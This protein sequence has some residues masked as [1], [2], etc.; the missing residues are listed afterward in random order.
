M[1][2][3]Q[4]VDQVASPSGTSAQ[5]KAQEVAESGTG[6]SPV[7]K[8]SHFS[9]SEVSETSVFPQSAEAN[10]AASNVSSRSNAQTSSDSKLSA[11]SEEANADSNGSAPGAVVPNSD[12]VSLPRISDGQ[13]DA[14]EETQDSRDELPPG[15]CD[16]PTTSP[17]DEPSALQPQTKDI[18]AK[19]EGTEQPFATAESGEPSTETASETGT[20]AEQSSA[21]QPA[22][23]VNVAP[24]VD[25]QKT[26]HCETEQLADS[27][28]NKELETPTCRPPA[29]GENPS[30]VAGSPKKLPDVS[31]EA[32]AISAIA[33]LQKLRQQQFSSKNVDREKACESQS[34]TGASAGKA[35]TNAPVPD[36]K[37]GQQPENNEGTPTP[38]TAPPVQG[39]LISS[40]ALPKPRKAVEDEPATTPTCSNNIPRQRDSEHAASDD[41][42][43]VGKRHEYTKGF[44]PGSVL[45][46]ADSDSRTVL[47]TA[48]SLAG[49]TRGQN[50]APAMSSRNHPEHSEVSPSH[51]LNHNGVAG[52]AS[53]AGGGGT[54]TSMP[55]PASTGPATGSSG[56]GSTNPPQTPRT[57]GNGDEP[58]PQDGEPGDAQTG[59]SESGRL[60]TPES[61]STQSATPQAKQTG[62]DEE[63]AKTAAKDSKASPQDSD[64][65]AA[66]PLGSVRAT[67]SSEQHPPKNV[68]LSDAERA[69]QKRI[70]AAKEAERDRLARL[71]ASRREGKPVPGNRRNDSARSANRTLGSF[72]TEK[73]EVPTTEEIRKGAASDARDPLKTATVGEASGTD[74]ANRTVDEAALEEQ[75]KAKASGTSDA[76]E[77]ARECTQGEPCSEESKKPKES[78]TE[79]LDD[80]AGSKSDASSEDDAS[81]TQ[82]DQSTGEESVEDGQSSVATPADDLPSLDETAGP[83]AEETATSGTAQ[84]TDSE[85]AEPCAP[86]SASTTSRAVA[87]DVQLSKDDDSTDDTEILTDSGQTTTDDSTENPTAAGAPKVDSQNKADDDEDTSEDNDPDRNSPDVSTPANVADEA[88]I[89]NDQDSGSESEQDQITSLVS[90]DDPDLDDSTEN[91]EEETTETVSRRREAR[92]AEALA[93]YGD[94]YIAYSFNKG[95]NPP[96]QN[97]QGWGSRGSESFR[98]Y[99][100]SPVRMP[101][102]RRSRFR[103]G[104]RPSEV[105]RAYAGL[106]TASIN[107][108]ATSYRGALSGRQPWAWRERLVAQ[109]QPTAKRQRRGARRRHGIVIT[110]LVLLCLGTTG[111]AAAS[112]SGVWTPSFLQQEVKLAD[113]CDIKPSVLPAE[114]VSVVILNASRK[115]GLAGTVA[116]E[117]KQRDF[118]IR[119][120]GDD[121]K[122]EPDAPVTIRFGSKGAPQARTVQA[123]FPGAK[124]IRDDRPSTEV[125]VSL[126][127]KFSSL[128]TDEEATAVIDRQLALDKVS[129]DACLNG[130]KN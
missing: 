14:L 60:N 63:A 54:Q 26:V 118:N 4:D 53:N 71:R 72:S 123:H 106:P 130:V 5:S 45:A 94:H 96:P 127:N 19:T 55:T 115:A 95:G 125:T 113:D 70:T 30:V 10:P 122:F 46:G 29:V 64:N 40:A 62:A 86:K 88:V 33:R 37:I 68:M 1:P 119:S 110:L 82:I 93:K 84:E 73:Q 128:A 103:L 15:E 47:A 79:E 99:V 13:V 87:T 38:S 105:D 17:T 124:L 35:D 69:R 59:N 101:I 116:A 90:D 3:K 75:T 108:P 109:P 2:G 111:A 22:S 78:S 74:S 129:K 42:A 98:Y 48:S 89:E 126:Q 112:L 23:K 11:A 49:N 117:L 80:A 91:Y 34:G 51:P 114:K 32:G 107:R 31:A 76:Q 65:T 39:T 85:E 100:K 66:R 12:S 58:Q 16:I 27:A 9:P 92:Q 67:E 50:I 77:V 7:S 104:N 121:R 81:R 8:T 6:T 25:K 52:S 20:L 28:R 102:P 61:T 21:H 36:P 44:L 18:A 83:R 57:G 43:S 97:Y 24:N 56:G 41:S 120:V